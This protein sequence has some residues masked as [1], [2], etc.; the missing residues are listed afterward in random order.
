MQLDALLAVLGE[1]VQHLQRHHADGD[2]VLVGPDLQANE[3]HPCVQLVFE[4]LSLKCAVR[5]D[6]KKKKKNKT[7]RE[8]E[9]KT[10]RMVT[11]MKQ[12]RERKAAQYEFLLR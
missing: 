2:L 4:D 12:N 8:Q 11:N 7:K 10:R 6:I 1:V 9:L 5:G 3:H